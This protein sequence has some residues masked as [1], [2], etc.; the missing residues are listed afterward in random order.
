MIWV[1]IA[2]MICICLPIWESRHEIVMIVRGL[3][4]LKRKED[5]A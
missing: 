4:G 5:L 1:L 2:G 3:T